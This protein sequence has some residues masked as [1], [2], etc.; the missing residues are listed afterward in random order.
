MLSLFRR[1]TK[2]VYVQ[3][4]V[5][6]DDNEFWD[7]A[8]EIETEPWEQDTKTTPLRCLSGC[9]LTE[10]PSDI[11]ELKFLVILHIDNNQ[12]KELPHEIK[13]LKALR[14][15]NLL[16]NQITKFDNL[17]S[18]VNLEIVIL[19]DNEIEA[20]PKGVV[21]L[22][23]LKTLN[24]TGNHITKLGSSKLQKFLGKIANFSYKD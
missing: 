5:S 14:D 21:R 8:E 13:N 1:K 12:I 3:K 24:L 18:L 6:G 19:A 23:K 15:I 10:I 22:K 20:I 4:V 7:S 9:G 2:I 16:G 17:C 11:F